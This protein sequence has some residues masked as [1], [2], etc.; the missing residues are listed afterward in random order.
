[1]YYYTPPDP[2]INHES[3]SWFF[4]ISGNC[5]HKF[6]GASDCL[7]MEKEWSTV[8]WLYAQW[9]GDHIHRILLPGRRNECLNQRKVLIEL[10][11][12]EFQAYFDHRKS[13]QMNSAELCWGLIN[14]FPNVFF[15]LFARR[16]QKSQ[17]KLSFVPQLIQFISTLPVWGIIGGIK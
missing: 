16:Y 9:I 12:I 10:L 15:E 5:T 11:L 13:R 6:Y 3:C 7:S 8:C 2:Y 14:L 1:M 4:R 17:W